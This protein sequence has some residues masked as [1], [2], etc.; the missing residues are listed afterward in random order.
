MWK[1]VII[2]LILLTGN[3]ENYLLEERYVIKELQR[4]CKQRGLSHVHHNVRGLQTNL[5]KNLCAVVDNHN[6]DILTLSETHL[7]DD[8]PQDLFSISGIELLSLIHI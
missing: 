5:E 1:V 8:E 3:T 4:I 7:F 6:I 2:C